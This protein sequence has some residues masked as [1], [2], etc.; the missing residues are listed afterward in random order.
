MA[1]PPA[2]KNHQGPLQILRPQSLAATAVVL[3]AQEAG[4][5]MGMGIAAVADPAVVELQQR[6]DRSKFQ[7]RRLKA[8]PKVN[9]PKL[10]LRVHRPHPKQEVLPLFKDLWNEPRFKLGFGF[11]VGGR[12]MDQ[13][14]CEWGTHTN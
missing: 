5:A 13:A 14:S 2:R 4:A 11:C 8:K 3:M 1:A 9:L 10:R 7:G 12:L 6:A